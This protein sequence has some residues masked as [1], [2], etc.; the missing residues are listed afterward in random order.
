MNTTNWDRH[1]V[2]KLVSSSLFSKGALFRLGNFR[3]SFRHPPPPKT[4]NEKTKN[5]KKKTKKKK[6]QNKNKK[7]EKKK[8]NPPRKKKNKTKTAIQGALIATY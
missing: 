7:Q 2:A 1:N 5:K 4:E 8:N 3:P 6:I